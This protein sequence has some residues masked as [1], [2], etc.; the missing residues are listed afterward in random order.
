MKISVILC[1]YNRAGMLGRVLEQLAA[2]KMPANWSWD[3]LVVDNNSKDHTAEVVRAFVAR[4]PGHFGYAHVARQGKSWALNAAVALVDADVLAFTDD[5]VDIP[6]DWLSELARPFED[7][8]CMGVGGRIV[9]LFAEGQPG[10]LRGTL[11]RE[12]RGPLVQFDLGDE[13]LPLTLAPFGA[14]MAFRREIFARHGAFRTDLG[15]NGAGP[16]V[17]EDTELVLRLLAAGEPLVYA[18]RALVRHP[19]TADRLHRRYVVRWWYQQGRARTLTEGVASDIAQVL[20]VPRYLLRELGAAAMQATLTMDDQTRVAA[21]SRL[22]ESYGQ[23][24]AAFRMGRDA[25]R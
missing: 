8:A 3:V 22:A 23:I 7:A 10:W 24:V 14:N 4:A 2:Q 9:P 1:T 12:F 20:G 21:L 19:V 13:T 15:P 6:T 25:R 16:G 17:G 18:P 5:D 11:P